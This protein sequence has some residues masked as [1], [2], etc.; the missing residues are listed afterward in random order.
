MSP[1]GWGRV[2]WGWEGKRRAM[3][4]TRRRLLSIAHN[5]YTFHK[6]KSLVF[7]KTVKFFDTL[8]PVIVK[9]KNRYKL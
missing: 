5:V 2:G 7:Y 4:N 6:R 9:V 3:I 8:I 1:L